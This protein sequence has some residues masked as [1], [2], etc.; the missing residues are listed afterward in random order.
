VSLREENA[1]LIFRRGC[2]RP[3]FVCIENYVV[4]LHAVSYFQ[5]TE[6]GAL[7]VALQNWPD[8]QSILIPKTRAGRYRDLIRRL[9]EDSMQPCAPEDEAL[10]R[11]R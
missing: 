4:N 2:V 1:I 3:T 6:D 8:A 7:R 9:S 11:A 10:G 5:F